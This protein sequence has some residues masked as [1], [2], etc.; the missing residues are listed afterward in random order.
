MSVQRENGEVTDKGKISPRPLRRGARRIKGR[1]ITL[2]FSP[3]VL[4]LGHSGSVFLL[5]NH[6]ST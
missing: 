1:S 2:D 5:P 4:S 6:V 3:F